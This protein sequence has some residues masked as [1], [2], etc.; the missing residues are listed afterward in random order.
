MQRQPR[1]TPRQA[2]CS[3]P[4]G[5]VGAICP[6]INGESGGEEE[7]DTIRERL[8]RRGRGEAE[9]RASRVEKSSWLRKK[10]AEDR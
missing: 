2:T 3:G 5:G 6:T 1:G 8:E 9:R 7:G 4:G 10:Q